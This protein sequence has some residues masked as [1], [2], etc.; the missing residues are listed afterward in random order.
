[1]SLVKNEQWKLTAT[2]L[3]GVAIAAVAV[4]TIAPLAAAMIGTVSFPL[5]LL[6]GVIWTVIGLSLHYAARSVLRRLI[7]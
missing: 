4:G 7:E 5:A 1:M 6:S 3:N 2:W